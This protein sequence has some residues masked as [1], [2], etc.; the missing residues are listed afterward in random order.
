MLPQPDDAQLSSERLLGQ[1]AP[2]Q[3]LTVVLSF[4]RTEGTSR[5]TR[6]REVCRAD[7]GHSRE[8]HALRQQGLAPGH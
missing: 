1:E 5:G 3:V 4:L 6:Q 7:Q 8:Q 2:C